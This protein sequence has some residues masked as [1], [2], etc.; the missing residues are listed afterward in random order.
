MDHIHTCIQ[1]KNRLSGEGP[2]QCIY[3]R[4]ILRSSNWIDEY[5]WQARQCPECDGHLDLRGM[6]PPTDKYRVLNC[7]AC[8][9]FWLCGKVVNDHDVVIP[10]FDKSLTTGGLESK[11]CRDSMDDPSHFGHLVREC[12]R[13]IK[14]AKDWL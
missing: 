14:S 11:Y 12:C 7:V 5:M 1:C 3:G 13:L 8:S 2:F 10:W 6:E 4:C 9:K